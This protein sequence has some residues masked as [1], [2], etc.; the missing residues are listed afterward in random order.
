LAAKRE[1]SLHHREQNEPVAEIAP[2]LF[3]QCGACE[4]VTRSDLPAK[5]ERAPI[6]E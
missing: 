4:H 1:E 5:Q 6:G 2:A 3:R